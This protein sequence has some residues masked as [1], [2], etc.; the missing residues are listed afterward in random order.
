[1]IKLIE[2]VDGLLKSHENEKNKGRYFMKLSTR[3]PKDYS[4]DYRDD[5]EY[6][7]AVSNLKRFL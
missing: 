4:W 2:R 1:M 6:E 5:K 7:K 3:S